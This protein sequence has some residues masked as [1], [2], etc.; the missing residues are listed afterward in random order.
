MVFLSA[1]PERPLCARSIMH[2][3]RGVCF[4]ERMMGKGLLFRHD[5]RIASLLDRLFN[6]S[7]ERP[8]PKNTAK[9]NRLPTAT[10]GSPT[11]FVLPVTFPTPSRDLSP[12]EQPQKVEKEASANIDA[13]PPP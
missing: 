3:R 1:S 13:L 9:A 12:L 4:G 11:G 5:Q 2:V 8:R 7:R 6:L 10:T